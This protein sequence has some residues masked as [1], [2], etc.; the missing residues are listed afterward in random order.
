MVVSTSDAVNITAQKEIKLTA[1]GA[2]IRIAGGNIY[3][4]AP[5]LVEVKGSQ[6][7]FEGPASENSTV[8]LPSTEACAQKFASAA[9]AG[10]AIVD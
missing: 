2:T 8:Q 9:R 5:G 6:H 3:V 4:H 10:A 1:G 7:S